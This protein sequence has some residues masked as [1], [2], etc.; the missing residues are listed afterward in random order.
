MTRTQMALT[1]ALY[2]AAVLACA[3]IVTTACL[4]N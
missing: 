1:A 4:R 2:L 3:L